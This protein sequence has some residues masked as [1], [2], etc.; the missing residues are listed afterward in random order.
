MVP[1]NKDELLCEIQIHSQKLFSELE[2]ISENDVYKKELEWQVK[3]TFVSIHN[4]L[5]Y[6]VGWWEL[7]LK[8]ENIKSSWKE[9][10]FPETGYKWN[11]L[12]KLAQK[13]YLDYENI[14]FENLKIKFDETV[15]EIIK[16]IEW[17]TNE[18]LYEKLW[19]TKWTHGR[20]IQFNTSSPYKNIKS[21]IVK[22]RKI[23]E[24][25]KI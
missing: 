25:N 12:W 22:W 15:K 3:D 19:Y 17:K 11:E 20:M 21:K 24:N 18:E 4:L 6:L 14:S 13:F 5:S 23:Q 16:M 10:V 7:V 9:P 8:W 1:K 2:K